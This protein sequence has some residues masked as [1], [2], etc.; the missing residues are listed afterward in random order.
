ME[1]LKEL[2]KNAGLEE[3]KIDE[4]VA[5]FN[6]EVP[7]HL[8]PKEKFNEV[9]E[10]KRKAEETLGERDKQLEELSK[11]AGAS[12]ELK[13][14]IETLQNENKTAKE[15]YE[16]EAKELKLNTA[17]K[18]SLA[19]KV[20]DPDIV[21]GLLDKTKLE[22]DENDNIKA[23]LDDQIKSLQESKAFLFVP[24][25]D[26]TPAFKGFKPFEGKGPNENN[27]SNN[28]FGKQLAEANKQSNEAMQKAQN[29]YFGGGN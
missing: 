3:S 2:L 26:D 7:K 25:K 9:S 8:I 29:H 23:G 14:Q 17:L 15:K 27:N 6:K 21:L 5:E 22:L 12:E 18:L 28:N 11:S 16:T 10:A 1:W 24:E 19:G 13:K 4:F 20:H